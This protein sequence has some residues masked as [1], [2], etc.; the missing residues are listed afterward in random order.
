MC[1]RVE[2]ASD[3]FPVNTTQAEG[4]GNAQPLSNGTRDTE[5]G[6]RFLAILRSATFTSQL[7]VV[8]AS[9][10]HYVG[11]D[12]YVTGAKSFVVETRGSSVLVEA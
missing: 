12:Q 10:R 1:G 2:I 4:S 11:R 5:F 8:M 6:E 3:S 7:E 9:H